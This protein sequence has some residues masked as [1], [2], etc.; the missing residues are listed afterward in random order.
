[1][2]TVMSPAAQDISSGREISTGRRRASVLH[3]LEATSAGA[4]RYVADVLLNIDTE[5][6]K[7]TFVYSPIRADE[8]FR[9][10][11]ARIRDRGIAVH[12]IPMVRQIDPMADA[13]SFLGLRQVIRDGSFDLVHGHSSKAGFL[14]RLAARSVSRKIVTIYSPHAIAI[15][16]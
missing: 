13:Q 8:R 12:E 7:V 5:A 6:F 16:L 9:R 1:M 10:D 14:A 2:S 4:A 15:A 3:V 11:L